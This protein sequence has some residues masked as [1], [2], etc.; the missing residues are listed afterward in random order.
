MRLRWARRVVVP[1]FE[2]EETEAALDLACRLA[3]ERRARIVLVAPLVV[4]R[5]LLLEAHFHTELARLRARLGSAAAVAE[6][7][8]VATRRRIVRTRPGRFGSDVA[9]LAA[10]LRAELVVVGAR[11]ESRRGFHDAFPPEVL[12][13]VRAA[14]CRVVIATA[15]VSRFRSCHGGGGKP[16]SSSASWGRTRSSPPPTAT[17]ARRSTTRSAS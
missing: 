10:R 1:L 17:S 3:A 4:P 7:Q 15:P 5:E 12:R 13:L 14:P 9:E 8:G 2:G 16:S 11:V 6:S